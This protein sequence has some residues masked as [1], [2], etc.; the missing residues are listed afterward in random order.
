MPDEQM[1]F[2]YG[3]STSERFEEFHR[4][5]P[6][7]YASLVRLARQAHQRGH[8]RI[9]IEL[10]F[11]VLR[12]EHLLTTNDPSSSFKLNDHYTS[13]YSRLIMEQEPDLD[14]IFETRQLKTL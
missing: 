5:N 4:L 13:R 6:H 1:S 8:R 11:A 3:K 2:G 9:G 10:L 7:V 14:D 12:W